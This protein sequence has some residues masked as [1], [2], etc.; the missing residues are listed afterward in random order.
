MDTA[1]GSY[2]YYYRYSCSTI[3]TRSILDTCIVFEY[4][5]QCDHATSFSW[6]DDYRILPTVHNCMVD[7]HIVVP[8]HRREFQYYQSSTGSIVPVRGSVV[9][10]PMCIGTSTVSAMGITS[11]L[12]LISDSSLKTNTC[13]FMMCSLVALGCLCNRWP[14]RIRPLFNIHTR[15]RTVSGAVW[16]G[17]KILHIGYGRWMYTWSTKYTYGLVLP[18]GKL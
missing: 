6:E 4:V 18:C 12:V 8:C 10:W 13:L 5:L 16:S 1:A 14:T 15:I 3:C 2:Y 11:S 9:I 17:M 7:C